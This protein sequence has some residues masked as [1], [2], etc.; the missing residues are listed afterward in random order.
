MP[1]R[2]QRE[3]EAEKRQKKLEEVQAQ[4]DSGSLTVRQMTPEEKARWARP[5]DSKPDRPARKKG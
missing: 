1:P 2:T 5:D 4:L 3:R